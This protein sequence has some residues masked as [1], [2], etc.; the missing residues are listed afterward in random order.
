MSQLAD[1]LVP[2]NGEGTRATVLRWCKAVGDY[3]DSTYFQNYT[4]I[5]S[6]NGKA[7]SVS[8]GAD[9]PD[10]TDDFLNGVSVAMQM[11]LIPRSRSSLSTSSRISSSFT[12]A[13]TSES[14]AAWMRR[15][16]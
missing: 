4:L 6:W 14:S 10:A 5:E 3:L 11:P 13:A 9:N 15:W 12:A 1:V 8:G 2:P 7:W 16:L